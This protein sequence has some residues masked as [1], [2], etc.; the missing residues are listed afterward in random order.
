[1]RDSTALVHGGA[2]FAALQLPAVGAQLK[3]QAEICDHFT[4]PGGVRADFGEFDQRRHMRW[5]DFLQLQL[6]AG[7]RVRPGKS[8]GGKRNRTGQ[9]CSSGGAFWWWMTSSIT[10]VKYFLAED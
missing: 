1:M 4:Q 7:V 10:D 2:P 9:A 8:A 6:V 5:P 3:R